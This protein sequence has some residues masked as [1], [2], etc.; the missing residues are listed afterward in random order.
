VPIGFDNP[1][2]AAEESGAYWGTKAKPLASPKAGGFAVRAARVARAASKLLDGGRFGTD[3]VFSVWCDLGG[4]SH[5]YP[6]RV[7]K[8]RRGMPPA[9]RVDDCTS[10]QEATSGFGADLGTARCRAPKGYYAGRYRNLSGAPFSNHRL[11]PNETASCTSRMKQGVP[12]AHPQTP[13][14]RDAQIIRSIVCRQGQS[15]PA[16]P[17]RL[18]CCGQA[19]VQIGCLVARAVRASKD[20]SGDQDSGDAGDQS[21]REQETKLLA[22][23][24]G[25]LVK[26]GGP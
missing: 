1:T 19:T 6:G 4:E 2:I 16:N 26:C 25:A 14:Q 15:G 18:E 13:L 23:H 3:G 11:I 8:A 7:S 24:C 17:N 20:I 12:S 22:G 21:K 5:A 9:G 10:G